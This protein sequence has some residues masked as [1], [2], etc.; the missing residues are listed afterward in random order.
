MFL[1]FLVKIIPP[2]I[3]IANDKI[4]ISISCGEPIVIGLVVFV[5]A[6]A[7]FGITI[8]E[9]KKY[10]PSK[11]MKLPRTIGYGLLI[12]LIIDDLIDIDK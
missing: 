6:L 12:N 2:I 10:A 8:A 7:M 3:K 5:K 9:S 4:T 1:P 11:S